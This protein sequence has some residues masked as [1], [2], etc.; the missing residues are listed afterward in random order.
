MI[1]DCNVDVI[2]QDSQHTP[3]RYTDKLLEVLKPFVQADDGDWDIFVNK[4][5][6]VPVLFCMVLHCIVLYSI[7]ELP[8]VPFSR[9]SCGKKCLLS[10]TNENQLFVPEN[11]NFHDHVR[12]HMYNH[13]SMSDNVA[14]DTC[15]PTHTTLY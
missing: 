6:Q 1:S 12:F 7:A 2:L 13:M 14:C 3:D 9:D 4:Y 11:Y 8:G 5:I 10:R 15:P